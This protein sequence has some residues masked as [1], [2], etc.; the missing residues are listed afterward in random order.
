M[1]SAMADPVL[2][3]PVSRVASMNDCTAT[4]GKDFIVPPRKKDRA[5]VRAGCDLCL[6][7]DTKFHT[8][9]SFSVSLD[10]GRVWGHNSPNSPW[11]NFVAC[12]WIRC[13]ATTLPLGFTLTRGSGAGQPYFRDRKDPS[14]ADE[15]QRV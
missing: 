6:T 14:G 12:L 10:T 11:S 4:I 15:P 1:S 2:L 7:E 5:A 3:Y 13:L 8:Y 9:R